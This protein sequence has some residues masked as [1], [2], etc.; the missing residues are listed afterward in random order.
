MAAR[1]CTQ[2]G[3]PLHGDTCEYCRV[4]YE[5][6]KPFVQQNDDTLEVTLEELRRIRCD[7][8]FFRNPC[9]K[10]ANAYVGE[11]RGKIVKVVEESTNAFVRMLQQGAINK[12]EF[13][14]L[15]GAKE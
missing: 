8:E 4:E 13:S 2:C 11:F 1:I 5:P 7:E 15:T 14:R 6:E 12:E 9:V 3:A 10:Y